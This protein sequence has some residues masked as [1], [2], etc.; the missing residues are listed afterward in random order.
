MDWCRKDFSAKSMK[1]K[2]KKDDDRIE[3]VEE[4]ILKTVN[5]N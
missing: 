5:L 2:P 3:E 4:E 1:R